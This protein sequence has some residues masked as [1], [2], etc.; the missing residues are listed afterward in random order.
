MQ[1]NA[2][3]AR[4]ID[5]RETRNV[6]IRI[7][8]LPTDA[9]GTLGDRGGRR[10]GD[11]L[12][13]GQSI[14]IA[15][16][17]VTVITDRDS[18]SF[19]GADIL[20]VRGGTIGILG[21]R[22]RDR[23]GIAAAERTAVKGDQ[24]GRVP[25][26]DLACRQ[27]PVGRGQALG[28]D[29]PIKGTVVVILRARSIGLRGVIRAR[30]GA[31]I[32]G[33]RDR[34]RH[35]R[36]SVAV[37][38]AQVC[39]R[40]GQLGRRNGMARAAISRGTNA[41]A[42]QQIGELIDLFAVGLPILVGLHPSIVAGTARRNGYAALSCGSARHR[43]IN[44]EDMDR[45]TACGNARGSSGRI[46]RDSIT[47]LLRVV[48][49][50]SVDL[51]IDPTIVQTGYVGKAKRDGSAR[52]GKRRARGAADRQ[53][54]TLEDTVRNG[55]KGGLCRR[56]GIR[57]VILII[58]GK[59]EVAIAAHAR[60]Y[61]EGGFEVQLNRQLIDRIS[62][63]LRGDRIVRAARTCDRVRVD[64]IGIDACVRAVEGLRISR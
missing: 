25:V 19:A 50:G 43:S 52:V 11:R 46:S 39:D 17:I 28:I 56:I 16:R 54:H 20:H 23:E 7:G 31:R 48:A 37:V 53:F 12:R 4:R 63:A 29:R 41:A 5:V 18:D 36:G 3:A 64:R 45:A 10:T 21:V 42:V 14:R 58:S 33:Q 40:T 49:C 38:V 13:G 44:H 55:R 9:Q 27:R 26:I 35:Y 61:R 8:I 2:L 57:G 1:R 47:E 22:R 6:I 24:G 30:V 60:T 32:A 59:R 15:H 62:Q 51:T 34:L